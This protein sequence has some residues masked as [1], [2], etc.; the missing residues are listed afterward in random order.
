M[1]AWAA[2]ADPAVA[3]GGGKKHEIYVAAFGGHLFYD[4]FFQ[5]RGAGSRAL[6]LPRIRYLADAWCE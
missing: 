5:G 6:A 4:L 2:V 3:G 1:L